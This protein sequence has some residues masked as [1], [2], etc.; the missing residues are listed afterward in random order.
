MIL[1]SVFQ[2]KVLMEGDFFCC[3]GDFFDKAALS[4]ERATGLIIVPSANVRA[5][6]ADFGENNYLHGS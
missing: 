2:K 5:T 1:A 6:Q 4:P 3:H